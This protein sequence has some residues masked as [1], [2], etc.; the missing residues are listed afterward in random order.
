MK[1]SWRMRCLV[2]TV[3]F[4]S[5][6]KATSDPK[7]YIE[8]LEA[9]ASDDFFTAVE[10]TKLDDEGARKEAVS[11][12]KSAGL[13]VVFGAQYLLLSQE[14]NLNAPQE[15]ERRKAVDVVKACFD[16][17][18]EFGAKIVAVLSGPDPGEAGR[19][20]GKRALARSLEE[21]CK[22]A[23]QGMWISL[24]NFDREVEKKCLIGPTREA[25]EVVRKVK[26]EVGNIGLTVD[27]S[28]LP[29]LDEEPEEAVGVAAEHLIHVHIGNCVKRDLS[30]PAY[31]DKHPRFGIESGENDLLSVHKFLQVLYYSGYF[32]KQLPTRLPMVGI[33]VKPMKGECPEIVLASSKRVFKEAWARLVNP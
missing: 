24:E 16:Q 18:A 29:L 7:A 26:E 10:L 3:H 2:S 15:S 11:I 32:T 12:V 6:P 27:L 17:A 28:H 31:G 9:I 23:P 5:F 25:V 1:D 33:E 30:H 21:L 14:L 22:E 19:E 20:E 13:E 4:M 8:G